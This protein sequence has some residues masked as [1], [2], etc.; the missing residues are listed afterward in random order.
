MSGK[1]KSPSC[2]E[3]YGRYP[4]SSLF[5]LFLWSQFFCVI[6]QLHQHYQNT[7]TFCSLNIFIPFVIFADICAQLYPYQLHSAVMDFKSLTKA[8]RNLSF[9]VFRSLVFPDIILLCHLTFDIWRRAL[10]GL[11]YRGHSCTP[12]SPG[13]PQV[14]TS[15][16]AAVRAEPLFIINSLDPSKL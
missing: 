11:L 3:S 1:I 8:P 10:I 15:A 2:G 9:M 4:K 5:T 6:N 16:G 7:C 14:T 13:S 12:A